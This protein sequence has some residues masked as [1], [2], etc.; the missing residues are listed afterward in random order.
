MAEWLNK[1][2]NAI[3]AGFNSFKNTCVKYSPEIAFASGVTLMVAGVGLAVYK[4]IKP[5]EE[6]EQ[7][8]LD[9]QKLDEKALTVS[10]EEGSVYTSEDLKADKAELA[11]RGAGV[12]AWNY[13]VPF[14]FLVGSTVCYAKGQAWQKSR[15]LT[16]VAVG[17]G[18]M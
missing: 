5:D 18:I 14:I 12:Y 17:T 3:K 6:V 1:A 15:T 4:S 16:A 8:K 13:I 9:I 11:V 10:D 7:L 2:T